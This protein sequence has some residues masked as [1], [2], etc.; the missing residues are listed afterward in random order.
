[1]NTTSCG[2]SVLGLVSSIRHF[3]SGFIIVLFHIVRTPTV[4]IWNASCFP[5]TSIRHFAYAPRFRGLS[6]YTQ[7]SPLSSSSSGPLLS[8]ML[9]TC[10]WCWFLGCWFVPC[11]FMHFRSKLSLAQQ[12]LQVCPYAGH[13][14]FLGA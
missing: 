10:C 5:F 2:V 4:L 11:P 6:E 1:M 13:I 14:S 3:P 7:A 8:L 12:W 9:Y